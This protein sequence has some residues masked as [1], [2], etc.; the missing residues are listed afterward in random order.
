[1]AATYLNLS[2]STQQNLLWAAGASNAVYGLNNGSV[3]QPGQPL[4]YPTDM[5]GSPGY[6]VMP[7]L[8]PQGFEITKVI[9]VDDNGLD[10]FIAYNAESHAAIVGIAGVNGVGGFA[11]GSVADTMSVLQFGNNQYQSMIKEGVYGEPD[12]HR[13]FCD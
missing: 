4:T 3:L 6:N 10:M 1:M 12:P 8:A 7:V 13:H 5:V 9:R 2:A 11:P